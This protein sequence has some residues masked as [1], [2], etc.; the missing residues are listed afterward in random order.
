M[1]NFCRNTFIMP[2]I[3]TANLSLFKNIPFGEGG[4]SLQFRIEMYN[5]FNHPSYTLG[6]GT[7]L[8]QTASTAPARNTA[9]ATPGASQFLNTRT[10][11]GGMGSAPFQRIIQWGL[12]LTF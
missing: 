5:A 7:I 3:N 11:S 9:F 6:S 2:G 10:F 4:R 12:K 1:A 8:G